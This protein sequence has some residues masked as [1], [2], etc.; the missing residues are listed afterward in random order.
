MVKRHTLIL[1]LLAAPLLAACS[2]TRA[3]TA[4][5]GNTLETLRVIGVVTYRQRVPLPPDASVTVRLQD[6]SDPEAAPI[7]IA[8]QTFEAKGR[9]VPL[10]FTLEFPSDRLSPERVYNVS[11]RIDSGG[12]LLWFS[13][14]PPKVMTGGAPSAADI[15]L[16]R[17]DSP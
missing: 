5:Q 6:A 17:P 8:E 9:Q 2:S 14:D 10:P 16:A 11:A 7:V 3:K 12:K 1:G 13:P 4:D 15:V